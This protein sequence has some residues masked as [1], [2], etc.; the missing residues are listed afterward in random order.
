MHCTTIRTQTRADARSAVFHP[1]GITFSIETARRSEPCR[2]SQVE[3]MTQ[4]VVQLCIGGKWQSS[5]EGHTLSVHDPATLAVVAEVAVASEDDILEALQ[6]AAAGFSIWRAVPTVSR[7]AVLRRAA[8]FCRER[9]TLIGGLITEEQGKPLAESRAE[10]ERCAE[11]FEWYADEARR[12]YGRLVPSRTSGLCQAVHYEPIGPV[13]AFSPWNFPASQAAKKLAAALAAGCSIVLKG[14]EEAPGACAE[15]VRTLYEAGVAP[16]SVSLLFGKP[17][18]ISE[19]LIS[20]DIIRK[21]SFTGSIPVGKELAVLAATYMKPCT[22]ELGGH[23]PVIVC[24]DANIEALVPQLAVLKFRNAGQTCVA[25]SRFFVHQAIHDRFV[26]ALLSRVRSLVV[27][28]G[29]FAETQVGPLANDRRISAMKEFVEDAVQ[30]GA[31]LQ[32][33]GAPLAS[34][35]HYFPPTILTEVPDDARLMREEIFG[36]VVPIASFASL[37][38][39]LRKANSTSYGLAAYAFT[40]SGSQAEQIAEVLDCGMVSINHL[41]GSAAEMP[42][43][44]RKE[45]G[46][47]SEGGPEGLFCYFAPKS[48]SLRQLMTT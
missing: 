14:P 32:C 4:R 38:E 5:A 43:G 26:E 35:G 15:L 29:R 45:S 10:V 8:D 6:L 13:A 40:S 1:S 31:V 27:G 36:P 20:S 42:F 19:R 12:A 28:D 2:N 16:G 11:I 44:G 30:R 7:Q 21:V 9:K 18:M 3:P 22:M 47:G 34:G 33:G 23:A 17:A 24:E 41:A 25:P 46:Y 48:V 37:D 39:A